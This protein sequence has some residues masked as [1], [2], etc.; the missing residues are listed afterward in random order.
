MKFIFKVLDPA[1]EVYEE[2]FNIAKQL[3]NLKLKQLLEWILMICIFTC[4]L[5]WIEPLSCILNSWYKPDTTSGCGHI[6]TDNRC[7]LKMEN[8]NKDRSSALYFFLCFHCINY[9]V[10]FLCNVLLS[11]LPDHEEFL[12]QRIQTFF[13]Q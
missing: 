2:K 7:P 9:C 13:R 8:S 1:R 5:L 6:D 10:K 4:L 12:N 11:C 3:M